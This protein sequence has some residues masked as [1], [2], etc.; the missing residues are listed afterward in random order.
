MSVT[1]YIAFNGLH[2]NPYT[3]QTKS[4]ILSTVFSMQFWTQAGFF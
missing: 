3:L 4:S 2:I 1:E